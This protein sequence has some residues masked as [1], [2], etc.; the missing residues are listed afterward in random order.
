MM[1]EPTT[2]PA[3]LFDLFRGNYATELLTAAVAHLGLF[4]RLG[5]DGP[6]APEALRAGLGL[7]R[8]PMAVL[9][10]AL[11]AMRLLEVDRAGRLDLTPLARAHLVAGSA[12]DVGDY[13]GLMAESPGVLA[14]VERL[15]SNRPAGGADA[16]GPGVAYIYREGIASAMDDEAAARH[17]TLAL[18]SRARNVAP[19]LARACSIDGMRRLLDVGGGSGLYAIAYLHRHPDLEAVVWDRPEVLKVAEELARDHGVADRLRPVAGDMFGDPV[20]TDCDAILLSNVLHD[21]DE[22]ECR[23]LIGRLAATLPSDG[24]LL[25]HDVFLD[26]D[27]GGPLELALYSAALFSLTEGRAYGA[28]EYRAWLRDAGLRPSDAIVPT[29]ARCGVLEARR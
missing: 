11:R 27:L 15:K 17:L 19:A 13:I 10:T 7:E 12:H 25:I 2:D 29:L 14:M 24:R 6:T 20:P 8:R 21:W 26:D 23:R 9:T 18:A 5:A 1:T 28:S 22:P 16:G 4:G 3:S